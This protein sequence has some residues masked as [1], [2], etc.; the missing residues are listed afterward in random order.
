M[1]LAS[2]GATQLNSLKALT[3]F[4]QFGK[5][6]VINYLEIVFSNMKSV[7]IIKEMLV[8]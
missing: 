1:N 6:S 8:F 5:K 4:T 3:I 7:I 2:R